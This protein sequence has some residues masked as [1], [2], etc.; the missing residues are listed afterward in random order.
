M[1]SW[2]EYRYGSFQV[3]C[4]IE[5]NLGFPPYNCTNRL[6]PKP[7]EGC[8]RSH[9]CTDLFEMLHYYSNPV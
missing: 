7:L 6:A 2:E 5:F 1:L 4:L 8:E 9:F 3:L